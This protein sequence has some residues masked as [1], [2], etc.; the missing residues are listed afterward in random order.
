MNEVNEIENTE[1]DGLLK[2]KKTRPPQ[3]EKQKEAFKNAAAK[4]AENVKMRKEQKLLDAQKA[5][6]EKEGYIKQPAKKQEIQF[7]IEEETQED[8]SVVIQK[9]IVK[10]LPSKKKGKLIPPPLPP[11][12]NIKKQ[13]KVKKEPQVIIQSE[14]SSDGGDSDDSSSE[15]EV[16]VIKRSRKYKSKTKAK[17]RE[18]SPYEEDAYNGNKGYVGKSQ[19]Q[20]NWTDMFC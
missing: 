8:K 19:P 1:N 9:E 20:I 3:S 11:K 5:L 18:Q 17:Q 13:P 2:K 12:E 4:R 10:E 6:L 7:E 14:S 15:D 16:I